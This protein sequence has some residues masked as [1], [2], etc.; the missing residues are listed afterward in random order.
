MP[1]YLHELLLLLFRNR[2]GSAADL[3]RE[4]D[5]QLP[6]YDQVRTES[7]D[8]SD[9]KPTE[10]RADL[11][12]FL[13]RE[14][15]KVL[16]VYLDLILIS[17]SASAPEALEATMNSLGYEYQSDFA[18]R[19]VA[20]GKVEGRVELTLKLLA[21]RF[22]PLPDTVRTRVRGAQDAQLDVV[23]ERML[24]AQTLEEALG[25]LY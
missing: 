19:Y 17:L 4:L 14:S 3:L 1:S 16:G 6:E 7:S 12:L 23:A 10:Y 11:V 13:V 21:W 24:T 8:L 22:G 5:V 18:R 25:S 20:Q 2:S 9:L 15:Q